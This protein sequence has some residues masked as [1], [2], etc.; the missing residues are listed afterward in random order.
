VPTSIGLY[1]ISG[2]IWEWC[3]EDSGQ[4]H[5]LRG[6]SWRDG[7]S[8][9]QIGNASEFPRPDPVTPNPADSGDP[10]YNGM[11]LTN[12]AVLDSVKSTYGYDPTDPAGIPVRQYDPMLDPNLSD[13][14]T[15]T[16]HLKVLLNNS[17][18]SPG[19]GTTRERMNNAL[20]DYFT[21]WGDPSRGNYTPF[22]PTD[23][24]NPL[25]SSSIDRPPPTPY[26]DPRLD[27]LYPYSPD[28]ATRYDPRFDPR[29]PHY[30]DPDLVAARAGYDEDTGRK[31]DTIGFRIIRNQGS[32]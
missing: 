25:Y 7:A 19:S 32:F 5:I 14:T 23:N 18:Y 28:Y 26:F 27:P 6:G 16:E 15:L 20:I 8:Y 22:S 9:L 29:N 21:Y 17:S 30:N 11:D 13:I 2:N 4:E 24:A 31:G 10:N 12:S 3:Y 1:D